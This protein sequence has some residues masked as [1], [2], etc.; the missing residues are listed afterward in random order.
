M[1]AERGVDFWFSIGST[2]TCLSVLRLRELALKHRIDFRRHPFNVR[3]IMLEIGNRPFVGKPAKL[4]YMWRDI[5]RRARRYGLQVRVPAPYPL[6]DMDF[7]NRLA[8][9]ACA[10]E[11]GPPYVMAAY[12][13]WFHDGW[14]PDREPNVSASLREVRQDPENRR[15]RKIWSNWPA[16]AR[17]HR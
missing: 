2:Y 4:A 13:W 5:D 17:A 9:L 14:P 6:D 7:A 16:T 1:S 10:H 8:T 11:W 12:R 15:T 3:D